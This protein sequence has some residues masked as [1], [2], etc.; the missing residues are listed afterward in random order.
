MIHA[1]TK[2][3]LHH[4]FN[5]YSSLARKRHSK[6]YQIQDLNQ[7]EETT[8]GIHETIWNNMQELGKGAYYATSGEQ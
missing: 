5:A 6:F 2:L 3:W 8:I 1:E 7:A 4:M